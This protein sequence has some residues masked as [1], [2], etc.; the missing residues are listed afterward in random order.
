MRK[1]SGT[2]HVVHLEASLDELCQG[3]HPGGRVSSLATHALVPEGETRVSP[4]S[5]KRNELHNLLALG[6][7]E[8]GLGLA[9]PLVRQV[10]VAHN[11]AGLIRGE[12]EDRRLDL[13]VALVGVSVG[14][15]DAACKFE[16]RAFAVRKGPGASN[17]ELVSEWE[18]DVD[19][20]PVDGLVLLEH[21]SVLHE[22]FKRERLESVLFVHHHLHHLVLVH[23]VASLLEDL[24]KSLG[25]LGGVSVHLALVLFGVLS[26]LDL[27]VE[28]R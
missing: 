13:V 6:V 17:L 3:L 27:R 5:L 1:I 25:V 24:A 21:G 23:H 9:G 10:K 14:V 26:G 16:R 12:S 22:F 4:L 8:H 15:V 11:H 28:Q 19:A 2:Y 7:L 20:E 18:H